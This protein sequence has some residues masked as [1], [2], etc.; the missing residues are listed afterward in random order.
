[1]VY[2]ARVVRV[3]IGLP[4]R[5]IRRGYKPSHRFVQRYAESAEQ[6]LARMRATADRL[7][8]MVEAI[9]YKPRRIDERAVE[10]EQDRARISH[11]RSYM[12]P[13]TGDIETGIIVEPFLNKQ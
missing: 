11:T 12:S 3:L 5:I 1:L 8:A 7:P 2:E 13:A 10:I 4:G 9:E 6:R